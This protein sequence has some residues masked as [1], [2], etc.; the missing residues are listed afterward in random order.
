M[1]TAL[2]K[3]ARSAA[4]AALIGA[5]SLLAA[6]SANALTILSVGN[7][8]KNGSFNF[9]NIDLTSDDEFKFEGTVEGTGTISVNTYVAS[10]YSGALAAINLLLGKGGTGAGT[11]TAT[12]GANALT[13]VLAAGSWVTQGSTSFAGTGV[14]NA[15]LLTINYK[16][17]K[18]RGQFSG[19]VSAV[20]VP[21][22]ALLLLSGLGGL[23]FLARRRKVANV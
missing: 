13:F 16:G 18:P 23:G 3:F 11:V 8:V 20:P 22:A 19:N 9:G 12:W 10:N 21:G 17:F 6:S 7:L 14:G 1:T 5:S 2:K 15:Q 4:V